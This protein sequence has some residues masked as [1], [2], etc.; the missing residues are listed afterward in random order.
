MLNATEIVVARMKAQWGRSEPV[1]YP[2]EAFAQ[3]ID[4]DGAVLPFLA[5][6]VIWTSGD[7]ES[8]GAPGANLQ[9]GEGLI[10][11]HAFVPRDTGTATA[12][13]MLDACRAIFT[14]KDFSGVVTQGMSPGGG[15]AGDEDGAYWRESA[16]W[17]FWF[18]EQG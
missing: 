18:D 16:N 4:T 11:A 7:Q 9:R 12:S 14:S 13:A 15:G 17:V 5:L 10:W 2:N 1:A 8:I 6:E 3:P